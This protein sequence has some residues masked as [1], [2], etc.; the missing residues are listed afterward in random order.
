MDRREIIKRLFPEHLYFNEDYRV[1]IDTYAEELSLVGDY[2]EMFANLPQIDRTPREFIKDIAELISIQYSDG[3]DDSEYREAVK[4]IF[5]QYEQR[6]T[7]ESIKKA[8]D[9]G[10]VPSWVL[11]DIFLDKNDVPNRRAEL[12]WPYK[13]LFR[14]SISKHSGFD[15]YADSSRWR[16]GVVIIKVDEMND[17]IR[18]AV[19]KVLPAG[20]RFYFDMVLQL[21]GEGESEGDFGEITFGEILVDEDYVIY[22]Y[23]PVSDTDLSTVFSGEKPPVFSGNPNLYA[24]YVI[25]KTALVNMLEEDVPYLTREQLLRLYNVTN[26]VD[27]L[28]TDTFKNVIKGYSEQRDTTVLVNRKGIASRSVVTGLRSG[29]RSGMR[30]MTGSYEGIYFISADV[31]TIMPYDMHYSVSEVFDKKVGDSYGDGAFPVEITTI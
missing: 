1:L 5:S 14:H 12:E 24:Y 6:G 20:I 28:L 17:K 22:Y 19:L 31:H 11:G 23:I 25:D 3:Y 8:A 16:D 26:S 10:N 30:P 15:K 4:R 21:A 18:E 27:L 29:A 2:I 13:S 7:E 9:Y